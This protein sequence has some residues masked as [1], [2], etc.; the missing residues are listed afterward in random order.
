[1]SLAIQK[2]EVTRGGK[3][4]T[5]YILAPLANRFRFIDAPSSSSPSSERLKLYPSS[6]YRMSPDLLNQLP[7]SSSPTRIVWPASSPSPAKPPTTQ[8]PDGKARAVSQ[9]TVPLPSSSPP[10]SPSNPSSFSKQPPSFCLRWRGIIIC[11]F[12]CFLK[13]VV[14]FLICDSKL[15]IRLLFLL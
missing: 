5:S 15:G 10:I 8:S 14:C 2:I 12:K 4:N 6:Q 9:S 11:S 1:M 13:I 7:E 3:R